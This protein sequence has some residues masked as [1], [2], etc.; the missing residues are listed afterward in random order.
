MRHPPRLGPRP[1]RVQG[2]DPAPRRAGLPRVR[3]GAARLRRHRRPPEARVLAGR[4]CAGGSSGSSRPSH[5]DEPV[6]L[7]G[8]S[9]GGGVAIRFAHDYPERVRSLVLVNS[10]G[11]SAWKSR[12]EAEVARRAS[13]VGLG[14]ALPERHLADPAGHEG[15]PDHARGRAAQPAAQPSS[16]AQGRLPRPARR[17]HLRARGAEASE[18][19]PSSCSGATRDGV[20]P[21]ESFDA[22]C[23]AVGAEGQVV[24]G[25]HSW[26]LADPDGFGE[27]IT[28]AV[29]VARVAR[30]LET[31]APPRRAGFLRQGSTAVARR[32][33]RSPTR[34]PPTSPSRATSGRPA[35]G[36]R[37][38]AMRR[39]P[40]RRVTP[41]ASS[42]ASNGTAYFR[43]V[44]SSSRSCDTRDTPRDAGRAAAPRR[45]PPA[46]CVRREPDTVALDHEPTPHELAQ[47]AAVDTVGPRA[48]R[49]APASKRGEVGMV[50]KRVGRRGSPG[51]PAVD[52]RRRRACGAP[53]RSSSSRVATSSP[54]GPAASDCLARPAR[55][56]AAIAFGRRR[57]TARRS[58]PGARRSARSRSAGQRSS[59]RSATTRSTDRS[60]RALLTGRTGA[61]RRSRRRRRSRPDRSRGARTDRPAAA[62]GRREVD[63]HES[64]SPRAAI[65]SPP[66][67]RTCAGCSPEPMYSVYAPR[68][69]TSW[70]SAPSTRSVGVDTLASAANCWPRRPRRRARRLRARRPRG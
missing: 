41:V 12:L 56:I 68:R 64:R 48:A 33:A 17:P 3:A 47:L 66:S 36:R 58:A 1:P 60:G 14:P 31:K 19:C 15:H 27:V 26:M 54:S 63:A 18:S 4:V 9:F 39:S 44:P 46:R 50:G 32:C 16:D 13:L 65:A 5:L 6:F 34:S 45:A 25:S 35:V 30:E 40:R 8:H 2:R 43:E 51:S 61:T 7:I 28:N 37:G 22:L 59:P 24:D 11:G 52:R 38:P 55:V 42:S 53:A 23:A 57:P 67:T 70:P 62:A 29:E 20:I 69:D 10:I 21:R 49:T